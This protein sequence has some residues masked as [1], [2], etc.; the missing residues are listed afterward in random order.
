MFFLIKKKNNSQELCIKEVPSYEVDAFRRENADRILDEDPCDIESLRERGEV[1]Q[2]L[3]AGEFTG[4][5]E[6]DILED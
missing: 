3:F 5:I 1:F 2:L 6:I 4:L